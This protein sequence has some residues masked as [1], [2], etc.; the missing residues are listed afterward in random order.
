MTKGRILQEWAEKD[1]KQYPDAVKHWVKV[2]EMLKNMKKQPPEYFEVNY[3]VASCLL[4]QARTEK[5]KA[6]AAKTALD[7]EKVL[8]SMLVLNPTLNKQPDMVAR[9][10]ELIKR[11]IEIQGRKPPPDKPATDAGAAG[12]KPS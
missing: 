3:N 8:K 11:L 1:P 4:Y 12:K 10:Q 5:D 6:A 2:R 7:G 9:Y